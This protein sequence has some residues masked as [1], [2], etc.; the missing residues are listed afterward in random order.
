LLNVVDVASYQSSTFGTAGVSMAIV[1]ATES[2]GY[3]NPRY[4]AQVAHARANGLVVG[5]YHFGHH[6][7]DTAQVDYFLKHVSLKPGDVLAFDWEAAGETQAD[8]D[9]FMKYLKSKAP[10]YRV[11][12]YCNVDFW[13]HK[14]S[15]SYVG[16]G[17]WIADPNHS[18]GHPGIKHAWLFHQYSTAGGIDHSVANFA[19]L[20]ALKAWATGLIPK[21]APKPVAPKPVAP[22]PVAPKPVTPAAPTVATLDKRVTT[23]EAEVKTLEAKV[24]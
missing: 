21:P 22:K 23:L 7:N 2:T 3:V 15:E 10:Q 20:A 13:T 8:R 5:H 12:L 24:K 9:A 14:D 16:D 1:K 4:A 19:N 17:L 6:G 11:I 18:A